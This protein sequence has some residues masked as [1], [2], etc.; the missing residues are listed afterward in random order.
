MWARWT[1]PR[2]RFDQL[3]NFAWKIMI[4]VSLVNLLLTAFFLKVF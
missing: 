1:Y 4:P 2:I 3:M